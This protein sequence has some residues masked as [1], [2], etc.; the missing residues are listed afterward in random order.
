MMRAHLQKK[1]RKRKISAVPSFIR[2][3]NTDKR[4]KLMRS[5]KRR[6]LALS[7]IC[8][9]NLDSHR[10]KLVQEKLIKS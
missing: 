8:A 1:R 3:D 4:R 6:N 5:L 9:T 7:G 10:N 2:L